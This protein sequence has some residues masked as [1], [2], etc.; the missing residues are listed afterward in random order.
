MQDLR[1]WL[2]TCAEKGQ[3]KYVSGVDSHLEMGVITEESTLRKG[4][5]LLFENIPGLSPAF[6]VLTNILATPQRVGISLNLPRLYTT[7]PELARELT[8]KPAI[9]EK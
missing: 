9:W 4:P 2:K 3:L 6:R 8:G 5:A 1:D 7:E